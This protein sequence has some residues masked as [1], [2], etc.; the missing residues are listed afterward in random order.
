MRRKHT[1]LKSLSIFSLL[2]LFTLI[3]PATTQPAYS[4]VELPAGQEDLF[5]QNNIL[6]YEPGT[7]SRPTTTY[8]TDCSQ[9][10]TAG[11]FSDVKTDDGVINANAQAI[12]NVLINNGYDIPAIAGI[13]G[14]LE[15]EDSTLNPLD[16]ETKSDCNGVGQ[17]SNAEMASITST[18]RSGWSGSGICG[19]GIV[20][21]TSWGRQKGLGTYANK[22]GGNV[23]SLDTQIGYM[24]HE[25]NTDY[26]KMKVEVFNNQSL[27][28]TTYL[29]WRYYESP[30]ASFRHRDSNY[31]DDYGYRPDW[32]DSA[33][34]YNNTRILSLNDVNE[35][36][37]K[38]AYVSYTVSLKY[39][40]KYYNYLIQQ[41][42]TIPPTNTSVDTSSSTIIGDQQ[43]FNNLPSISS[44][45]TVNQ[46]YEDTLNTLKNSTPKSSIIL[47]FSSSDTTITEEN[48]KSIINYITSSTKSS[49]FFALNSQ[50]ESY[51]AKSALIKSVEGDRIKLISY[52]NEEDLLPS[53]QSSQKLSAYNQCV[54]ESKPQTP[55][56]PY[57]GIDYTSLEFVSQIQDWYTEDDFKKGSSNIPCP[58]GTTETVKEIGAHYNQKAILIKLC[59]VPSINYS[60]QHRDEKGN[61][62][63]SLNTES[64][65]GHA[66]IGSLA[67]AAFYGLGQE[68]KTLGID[69]DVTTTYRSYEY[70]DWIYKCVNKYTI[71][72]NLKKKFGTNCSGFS[73]PA[74][75]GNSKHE[76]GLAMDINTE[77]KNLYSSS[78]LNY[79]PKSCKT[80]AIPNDPYDKKEENG[81]GRWRS[82]FFEVLCNVLPKYGI[83][84]TVRSEPWHLQYVG[85]Y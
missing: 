16:I 21:W 37:N 46:F 55:T 39:A 84:L 27:E 3:L 75:A 13:M 64:Y 18:T 22:T 5:I 58:T 66:V 79:D 31:P 30:G 35:S 34:N 6:F 76:S 25:F 24:I 48:V 40:K 61:N 51:T 67:A 80:G 71:P 82:D 14:N 57:Q 36:I 33:G 78:K 9:Y 49:V 50:D 28:Q 44:F 38:A 60:G 12:M 45:Q 15:R 53:I 62:T 8:A 26:T 42:G 63:V 43:S 83:K 10:L 23:Q 4:V 69:L 32:T 72:E 20:Q 68:L 29:M 54:E 85:S 73:G 41:S 77:N 65:N 7:V 59:E 1:F 11:D 56:S 52:T 70:Q 74:Q 19:Y 17:P 81:L 47:V 2:F